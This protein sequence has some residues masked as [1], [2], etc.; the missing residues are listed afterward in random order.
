MG[1][2]LSLWLCG[3]SFGAEQ[4]ITERVGKQID[5]AAEKVRQE[6]KNAAEQ[7]REGFEKVRASVQR[8]GV[9]ARVY[10][11]LH[12]DKTVSEAAIWGDVDKDG[13]AVLRGTVPSA[14]AQRKAGELAQETVG[15]NRV[16]NDLKIAPASATPT[17]PAAK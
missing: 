11:R 13:V 15:V 17:G 5:E 10:A 1:G 12:W 7:I 4:G 2:F 14:K 9:A 8:M 16:V 3:A 6:A